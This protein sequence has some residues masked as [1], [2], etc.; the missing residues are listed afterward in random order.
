MESES[1]YRLPPDRAGTSGRY[2]DERSVV[3]YSVIARDQGDLTID[4]AV[5][6]PVVHLARVLLGYDR[7]TIEHSAEDHEDPPEGSH[8]TADIEADMIRQSTTGQTVHG[9]QYE[10]PWDLPVRR[11][12]GLVMEILNTVAETG[13]PREGK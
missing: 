5:H 10:G 7:A 3:N 2:R 9:T 4:A 6:E 11:S 13:P 12:R 8:N 1:G